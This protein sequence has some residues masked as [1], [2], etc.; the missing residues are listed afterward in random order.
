MHAVTGKTPLLTDARVR[1]IDRHKY[2][3][4]WWLRCHDSSHTHRPGSLFRVG[5]GKDKVAEKPSQ[6]LPFSATFY[7]SF[8]TP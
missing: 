5:S 3:L 4:I 1:P 7:C 8:V 6:D 2:L